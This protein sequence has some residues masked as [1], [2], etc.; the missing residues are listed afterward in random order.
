MKYLII[1]HARHGKDTVAEMM[2][3]LYGL[4]FK[5]SSL[6]AAEIFIFDILKDKY[7]Y[8][9]F[10]ECYEDR[11]NHRAEWYELI[12]EYNKDDKARLAKE[13]LKDSD[14]YVGMRSN[15]E[16]EEC[17]RQGL[18]DKII[19]VFNYRKPSEDSSSFKIDMWKYAD[20]VVPKVGTLQDLQNKVIKLIY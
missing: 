15:A 17:V 13:I 1:G 8:S 12:E 11:V 18:F 10:I 2:N 14:I 3:N 7:N 6:A 16:I 4:T 20:V 9:T 19:G 5:S